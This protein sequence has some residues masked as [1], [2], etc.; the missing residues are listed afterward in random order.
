MI[1]KIRSTQVT[2]IFK[3]ITNLVSLPALIIY[4]ILIY[5]NSS[6]RKH[7]NLV[8]INLGIVIAFNYLLKLLFARERP[9]GIALIEETGYSFPT[10]HSMVSMAYFGLLIYLI[11]QGNLS[12]IQKNILIFLF[13]LLIF[14]IGVSRI[15]LGVH[16][17]S[18][19]I[20]GFFLSMAY[21]ILFTHLVNN[22]KK[23]RSVEV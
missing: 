9:F 13:S 20:G 7:G 15:Y 1:G 2:T 17:P 16:Y 18:D 14:A 10:G 22:Y 6:T 11:Y 3:G 19:V 8:V 12:K 23:N 4:C 5:L 21:L